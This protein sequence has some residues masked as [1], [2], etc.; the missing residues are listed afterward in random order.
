M[1]SNESITKEPSLDE[2]IRVQH[3]NNLILESAGEGIYGIDSDGITTFLNP[4]AAKILGWKVAEL[5]GRPMHKILHHTKPDG[6]HYPAHECPIYAA[7][8]DGKVHH[9]EDEVF[10]H[11]DGS[12]IP[13]DY[14]S[15]PIY[16]K[17]RLLG[18][19]VVFT[20]ISERKRTEQALK[21][22][23][24][25]VAKMKDQL[26]AENIYLK[27]EFLSRHNFKDIIGESDAI[28][29]ILQQIELV[30]PTDANVLINGESGTGKELIAQAIHDRSER[31]QRPLIRVNCAAIPHELFESEF[32]GH[33][34]GAFT[35][36]LKNRAGRFEL[37]DNGTL[38]LDEVGEIPLDLQSKLLRVL[39]EGQFERIGDEKTRKIDVRIIA[40]TNKD[41][42]LM[43]EEN[44]FR[45]DLYYRLNVFP[46]ESPPLR[47]RKQDIPLLAKHFIELNC[48]KYKRKNAALKKA[49]ISQL[50]S[51]NWPGNI[52]ELQNVIER[53]VIINQ[54][55]HLEFNLPGTETQQ[56]IQSADT[57]SL[58]RPFTEA[59]R[60][61]QDRRNIQAALKLSGGK[62]SG[63]EG[64]AKLL[65]I[66]STTL[67]S[68]IK[69][70]GIQH[71][72]N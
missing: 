47:N 69:K 72:N 48:A 63:D 44:N 23:Y 27:E 11:K 35:G 53:A 37:A 38:F 28:G 25:E 26:E 21:A 64:A 12:S 22:A 14:T 57:M 9:I 71:S 68:R 32:F 30:A 67:A 65:G 49:N 61:Q 20:D 62:I 19:V 41:L 56:S 39:Q 10:W 33:I 17:E 5:L 60:L 50:E 31:N 54:N 24:T 43:V 18:A 51:Y 66:K 55:N 4:A 40:A 29:Q 15:T 70:L 52:R 7:F 34:K 59:E 8:K 2:L 45:E 1:L 58:D 46:I 36:A 13:V 6:S 3:Q 16:E 42:K